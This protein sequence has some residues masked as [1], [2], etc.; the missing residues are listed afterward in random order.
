MI[1]TLRIDVHHHFD[2]EDAVSVHGIL[3]KILTRLQT[4]EQQ[5]LSI[6]ATQ[7]ELS[8]EL[9]QIK[10]AVDIVKAAS[11]DQIAQIAAL[12]AQLAAGTPVTQDQLDALD[13]KADSILVA[14]G[15]PNG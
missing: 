7:Q 10:T 8:D 14:L 5:G 4:L 1:P 12:T 3:A 11:V 13:A 6:M 2:H 9:D 15:P